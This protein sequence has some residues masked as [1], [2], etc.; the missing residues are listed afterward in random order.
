ME[1]DPLQAFAPI[2]IVSDAPTVF[3]VTTALP[4]RTLPEF[5]AL[6]KANPGKF[7]FGSP[8]DATPPHLAA[9]LLATLAGI[10]IVHV[11]YKGAPLAVQAL[12][13]GDVQMYFTATSAIAPH[14]KSG[15]VRPLAVGG[16][17]RLEALPDVPTTAEAG[18]PALLT[19]NW[20]LMAAPRGTDGAIVERLASEVRQATA[21]AG[22]QK[23]FV[24]FG[25]VR[26]TQSPQELRAWLQSEADRWKKIIAAAGVK[27][28]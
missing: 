19:G 9:E 11:P 23:R 24:E 1:F 10:Q 28:Q 18:Y 21:D 6:A 25:M 5:V 16:P 8:G 26:G 27:A 7:N 20:W 14:I 17:R 4:S 12:L 15:K 2:A 3:A 22:A 13:A